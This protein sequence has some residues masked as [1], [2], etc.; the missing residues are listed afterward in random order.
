SLVGVLNILSA[1][2]REFDAD[3]LAFLETAAGEIAIAIE[4]A[5]LYS[6]TDAQLRRRI[7]QLATLQQMSRMVASTLDLSEVLR[8]ISRQ[9]AELSQATAAEIYR[10]PRH[11]PARLELMARHPSDDVAPVADRSVVVPVVEE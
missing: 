8:L 4:N 3:E 5:R 10:R 7:S 2:R 11:D 6:E 1:A 9:T